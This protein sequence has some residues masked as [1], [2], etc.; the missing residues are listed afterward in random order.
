ME[1]HRFRDLTGERF[2]KYT[3][4][5]RIP[6]NELKPGEGRAMWQVQCSC[7]SPP[8]IKPSTELTKGRAKGCRECRITSQTI[9]KEEVE[10]RLA[11]NNL[12][13][14]F[15]PGKTRQKIRFRCFCGQ[16]GESRAAA[17]FDEKVR[18]CGCISSPSGE[19]SFNW[20]GFGGLDS[21]FFTSIKIAAGKRGR[22]FTITIEDAWNLFVN[23]GMKCAISGSSIHFKDPSKPQK[24]RTASLDRIDSSRGYTLDNVQWVHKRINIMKSNMPDE[25]L[26][27]WAE[28]IYK[29]QRSKKDQQ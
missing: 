8:L 9:Q 16:I 20:A 7:G 12:E 28:L 15:Y 4:L 24:T 13:L 14:I 3:V 25:E 17:L 29:Y 5:H 26:V 22:E 21:Q 11:A 19:S 23:Q 18:S 6:R 10:K 27:N 1:S 2:G